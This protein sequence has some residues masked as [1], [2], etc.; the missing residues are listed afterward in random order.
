M[1][2]MKE[3]RQDQVKLLHTTNKTKIMLTNMRLVQACL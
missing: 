2:I 3:G 1:I